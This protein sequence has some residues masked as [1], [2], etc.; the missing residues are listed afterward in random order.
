MNKEV[1]SDKQGIALMSIFII[2]TSVIE[3]SGLEAGKDVWL[4]IVMAILMALPITL[5]Y[6]RLHNIFEGKNLFDILEICFGKFIGK[7]IGILYFWFFLHIGALILRS[8]GQFINTAILNDTPLAVIL[9][10]CAIICIWIVKEGIEAMGRMSSFFILILIGFISIFILFV[11]PKMDIRNIRPVLNDGIEPVL[12]G[13]ISAFTF[14]FAETIPIIVAFPIF[15][16]KESS[17]GILTK[18]LLIGGVIL[19][20]TSLSNILV[21]GVDTTNNVFFGTYSMATRIDIGDIIQRIEAV[22]ATVF[23]IG[24]CI[25]LSIVLLAMCKGIAKIISFDDYRLI[26]TPSGLIMLNLSYFIHANIMEFYE[27]SA[28]TWK[29]YVFPFEVI[30][31]IVIWIAAEIKKGYGDV[32]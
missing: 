30:L 17:Y 22:V 31:P 27:F 19:L 2:G 13:A 1:I 23:V 7:G 29:P 5:I 15:R 21:L 10:T 6:A 16:R 14:P 12:K 26:V 24:G 11:I 18:G 20:L 9:A 3:V 25:K 4:A 28:E 32:V 8:V